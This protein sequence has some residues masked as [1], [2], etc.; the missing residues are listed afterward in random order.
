MASVQ[1]AQPNI[2]GEKGGIVPQ[3][4][5]LAI[6]CKYGVLMDFLERRPEVEIV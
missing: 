4:N 2:V 3:P 6:L 5:M 1:T